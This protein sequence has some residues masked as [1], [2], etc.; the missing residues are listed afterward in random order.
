MKGSREETTRSK[1]QGRK[2]KINPVNSRGKTGNAV[3]K[4]GQFWKSE[5]KRRKDQIALGHN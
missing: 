4:K 2:K 1:S 3:K 5:E